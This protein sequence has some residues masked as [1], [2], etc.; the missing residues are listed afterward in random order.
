MQILFTK[1]SPYDILCKM[2]FKGDNMK[3]RIDD[4]QINNLKLIQ[5]P[6]YFCFGVDAVLLSDY[7]RS[8][9]DNSLIFEIGTGNGI[10][11]ILLS[12]KI[13]FKKIYSI[14][15]QKELFNLAKRNVE[16]NNLENNIELINDDINNIEKYFGKNTFDAVFTNPPYKKKGSGITNDNKYIEIAK[17]EITCSLENIIQKSNYLLKP[18]GKFFMIHRPDRLID[19]CYLMRKY[20]I[21][22]KRIQFVHSRMNEQPVLLLIEGVKNAKPFLK[23]DKPLYIYDENGNYTNEIYKIYGKE[24]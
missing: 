14:E 20:I 16:L 7:C 13:K 4:L 8:I 11:P 23:I 24:K 5:N 1:S 19:I 12:A 15:I 6:E 17:H 10:I 18:S 3:E 2:I 9:K 22:P 21:E